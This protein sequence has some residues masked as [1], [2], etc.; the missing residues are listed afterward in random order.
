MCG[1]AGVL[2][3]SFPISRE[4]CFEIARK[5]S[6]RGPD[7]CEVRIYDEFLGPGDEGNNAFFF[8][9]LAVID[10]VAKSNQPF[11]DDR[12]TLMFNGEIYNYKELRTEL[13]HLGFIFKTTSDT[14]VL[15]Y[16]L[17]KWK[18]NGIKKLNGMFS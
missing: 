2:N 16:A 6:F 10:F 11:E 9:R 4:T 1:F 14:E 17:Q 13:Q 7:S 12:Y 8:N 15:F 5:V 3:N 18:E